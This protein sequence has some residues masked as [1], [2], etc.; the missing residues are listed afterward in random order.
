MSL[1]IGIGPFA[2]PTT[3]S[4]NFDLD[5]AAPAHVLYLH[6]VAKRVRGEYAGQT[7]VDTGR[8][9]LLHETGLLPQWYVPRDDVAMDFLE[10]TDHHTHCPF[11]GDAS[12]WRL[13]VGD[14][15]EDN[16]VWGYPQP[17][18]GAEPLADLVAFYFDQLDAW[19]E[20]DE[21]IVGHP[22]DPFHR[23]DTRRSSRHVVVDV[24]GEVVADSQHPV[25]VFETGLPVRYYL[26]PADI[27]SD[28]LTASETT[29]ICPY[30]GLA[31][32]HGL[33]LGS[34]DIADAAWVYREPLGE[35]LEVR[36]HLSFFADKVRIRVDG[37]ELAG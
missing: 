25:M 16:A 19:Y 6:D 36:D 20:E 11:K 37:D 5:A 13:R 1:T 26:P 14:R 4:L 30:K 12:Y 22:R 32:Y 27:R 34:D 18:P 9:T 23:V 8:A 10:P 33:R 31:S 15:V 24:D 21:P 28:R 7:V 3:G 2:K 29:S 17:L 35:A